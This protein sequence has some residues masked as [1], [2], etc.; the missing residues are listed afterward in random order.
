MHR[1]I[2]F[3]DYILHIIAYNLRYFHIFF[4][5]GIVLIK[6]RKRVVKARV[7]HAWTEDGTKMIIMKILSGL[8]FQEL[9]KS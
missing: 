2:N 1:F 5:L 9:E 3:F 6:R 8:G 4:R 7:L